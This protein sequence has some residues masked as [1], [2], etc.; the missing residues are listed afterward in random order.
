M[1]DVELYLEHTYT[2]Q[3]ALKPP[4]DSKPP[5]L[6]WEFPWINKTQVEQI[7]PQAKN[8]KTHIGQNASKPWKNKT[9]IAQN[10][11]WREILNVR[12]K[13]AEFFSGFTRWVFEIL[14]KFA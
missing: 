10:A 4:H 14:G 2:G 8:F 5:S 1:N 9:Q 11:L 12:A 13:R 6:I 7:A 3:L